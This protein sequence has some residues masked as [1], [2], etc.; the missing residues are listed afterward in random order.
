TFD[1]LPGRNFEGGITQINPAADPMSRQFSVR[2]TLANSQALIKP[3]WFARVNVVTDRIL[4]PVAGPREAIQQTDSGAAVTVIHANSVASVGRVT[5]GTSDAS[6]FAIASGVE[7]G[8]KVVI[9]SSAPLKDGQ[10]VRAG[11]PGRPGSPGRQ[12]RRPAGGAR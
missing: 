11:G 4:A 7:P 10:K 5:V 12:A 6:H 3:G 8:E 9:L 1:A 2:V